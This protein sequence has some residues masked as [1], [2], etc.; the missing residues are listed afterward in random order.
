[1]FDPN[2]F[3]NE[4]RAEFPSDEDPEICPACHGTRYV[5]VAEDEVEPCLEC[6]EGMRCRYCGDP[7]PSGVCPRCDDH[8]AYAPTFP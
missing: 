6:S 5:Q 2:Q 7:D 1:M 3:H 8:Y 4:V